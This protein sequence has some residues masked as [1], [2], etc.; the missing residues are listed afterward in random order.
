MTGCAPEPVSLLDV[1]P[2]LAPALAEDVREKA[3]AHACQ[4]LRIRIGDVQTP[5]PAALEA[6]MFLV[7]LRYAGNG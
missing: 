6:G 3:R 4:N 5:L 2:E 7:D 1:A